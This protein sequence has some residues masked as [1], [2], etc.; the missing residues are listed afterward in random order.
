MVFADLKTW[1]IKFL[2]E[3]KPAV[4][5]SSLAIPGLVVDVFVF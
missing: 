3:V 2:V 5:P 1:V 4:L